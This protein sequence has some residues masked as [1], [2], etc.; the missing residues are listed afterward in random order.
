MSHD[1]VDQLERAY[2][3]FADQEA[4]GRSPL[5]VELAHGVADDVDVLTALAELPAAKPAES[6]VHSGTASVRGAGGLGGLSR[7]VLGPT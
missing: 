5:Y 1:E 7:A 2:E 6:A 4:K 3:C